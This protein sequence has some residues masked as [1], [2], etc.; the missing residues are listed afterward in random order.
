[1]YEFYWACL[2]SGIIFALIALIFDHSISNLFDGVFHVSFDFIQPVVIRSAIT[3]LGGTGILLTEYT[4]M[5][6]VQTFVISL[7]SAVVFSIPVYFIYVKPMKNVENSIGF[8]IKELIGK[9]GEVIVP[10]P[11]GGYGQILLK[12]VSGYTHEPATSLKGEAIRK[13]EIVEILDVKNNV[14]YVGPTV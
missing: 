9:T 3:I 12:T 13:G 5:S 11:I 4:T 1:M 2:V 14:L 10:I 8:S 6:T 7:L